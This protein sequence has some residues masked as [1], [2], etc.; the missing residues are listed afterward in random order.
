MFVELRIF[1]RKGLVFGADFYKLRHNS[2]HNSPMVSQILN[3]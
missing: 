2:P 3:Q 1:G